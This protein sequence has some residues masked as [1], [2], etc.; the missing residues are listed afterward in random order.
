LIS[1][2]FAPIYPRG[3]PGIGNPGVI[4]SAHPSAL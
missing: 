1:C 2:G 4:V 3:Q